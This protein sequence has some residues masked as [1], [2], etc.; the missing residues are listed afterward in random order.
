MVKPTLYGLVHLALQAYAP[1]GMR[2]FELMRV[3][4]CEREALR[5]T[6]SVSQVALV[7]RRMRSEGHVVAVIETSGTYY[8]LRATA[9]AAHTV[10]SSGAT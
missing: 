9:A 3:L 6:P 2:L 8:R 7:L 4:R 1:V 10:T 5:H